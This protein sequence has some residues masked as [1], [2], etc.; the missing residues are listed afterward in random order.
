M[1]SVRRSRARSSAEAPMTR[2]RAAPAAARPSHGQERLTTPAAVLSL[3]APL[4][5][6]A[7]DDVRVVPEVFARAGAGGPGDQDGVLG[8][9][10]PDVR[11]GGG[12][13]EGAGGGADDRGARG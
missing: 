7:A 6:V 5:G 8:A 1:S 3:Q 11:A 13:E 12:A 4:R 2:S 9:P 10:D